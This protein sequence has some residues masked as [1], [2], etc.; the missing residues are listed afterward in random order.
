MLMAKWRTILT[1]KDKEK[2]KAAINY[3]PITCLH[4]I[5]KLLA[6][7]IVEEIYKYSKFLFFS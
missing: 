5:W 7:V 6:G 3:R 1:Q 4:L 2:G